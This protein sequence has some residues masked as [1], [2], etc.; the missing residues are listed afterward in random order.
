V[1]VTVFENGA[2]AGADRA[3]TSVY[4]DYGL[5]LTRAMQAYAAG[6]RPAGAQ[7]LTLADG[8]VVLAPWRNAEAV[9]SPLDLKDVEQ[10]RAQLAE[11]SLETGVD[12]LTGAER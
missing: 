11:R 5:A 3:L 8:G 2:A 1:F 6:E 4:L 10:A 7:P 9:L 12:P